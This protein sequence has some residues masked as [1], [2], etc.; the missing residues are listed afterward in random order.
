MPKTKKAKA[1]EAPPAIE[2]DLTRLLVRY[3]G[4]LRQKEESAL[5]DVEIRLGCEP[6]A[7][8]DL[9]TQY[10]ALK[11][12]KTDEVSDAEMDN[13]LA[14]WKENRQGGPDES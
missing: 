9:I 6:G 14:E 5:M 10:L 3:L 7:G 13:L 1:V 8:R 4:V 11:A 12:T 2:D